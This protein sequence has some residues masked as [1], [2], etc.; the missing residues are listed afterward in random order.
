MSLL[1]SVYS[2]RNGPVDIPFR[3]GGAIQLWILRREMWQDG[4]LMFPPMVISQQSKGGTL[5]QLQPN[6]PWNCLLP[7]QCTWWRKILWRWLSGRVWQTNMVYW[8]AR[9]F[10]FTVLP[11]VLQIHLPRNLV[12]VS[13]RRTLNLH[14]TGFYDRTS[15]KAILA[16][17]KSARRERP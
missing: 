5:W 17:A 8:L 14:E 15:A 3:D 7:T 6:M 1:A 2:R 4:T 16:A 13:V 10:A 9:N 11:S 12:H